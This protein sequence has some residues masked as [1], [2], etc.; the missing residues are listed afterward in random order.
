MGLCQT[1]QFPHFLF[2]C[3]CLY[4][5]EHACFIFYGKVVLNE[6]LTASLEE[7][8]PKVKQLAQAKTAEFKI[9]A[10]KARQLAVS[11]A[12]EQTLDGT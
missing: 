4:V 8:E 5:S 7:V 11:Q 3:I 12:D 6:C 1:T 9:L 10:H 2:L